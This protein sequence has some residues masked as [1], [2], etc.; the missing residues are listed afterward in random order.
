MKKIHIQIILQSGNQTIRR[1]L[2]LLLALIFGIRPLF[3]QYG[4][5]PD[6]SKEISA[7]SDSFCRDTLSC[8]YDH[9]FSFSQVVAPS[10]LLATGSIITAVP[11]FH[12]NIDG[13]IRDFVQGF[14]PPRVHIDDYLQYT[15]LASVAILKAC[16]L[17]SEHRWRDLICLT[18]AS[19]LMGFTISTTLKHTCN[20]QRPD[21]SNALTS[22][23]SGHTTT[24]FLGAELLRR[25][26][27][28]E[29]PGIAV[30]GYLF[31]SGIACMRMWNNRHWFSDLL[32]GAGIAILSTSISY[33]LAP[34]LRF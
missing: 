31:A 26:Y 5:Q 16:G 34:K 19:C 3:A 7:V 24:A 25:E 15:P 11:T 27:G 18:G 23:P 20:V 22:F 8:G 28:R 30:A 9:G 17:E 1:L 2:L 13:T 12:T 32:G 6:S 10:L 29:Y 21:N 33:W 4:L 14:D